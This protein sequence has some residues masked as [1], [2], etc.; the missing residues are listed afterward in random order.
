MNPSTHNYIAIDV[1]KSTL[2]IQSESKAWKIKYSEP[3]LARFVR[4][5]RSL[6][7]PLVVFEATGGQERLLRDRLAESEIAFHMIN[8]RRIW[9]FAASEGIGARS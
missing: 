6:S 1:S 9:G 7:N 3:E 5:T 2:Q 8:P 4:E